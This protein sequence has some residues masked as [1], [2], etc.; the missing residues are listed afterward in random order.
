MVATTTKISISLPTETLRR[1]ERVLGRPHEGRSALLTRILTEAVDRALDE[2][3]AAG[4]RDQPVT[5]EEDAVLQ[6]AAR[7]GLA[8][9][10]SEE[11]HFAQR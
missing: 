10:T 9:A 11:Q 1:A 3:Y 2:Q 7:R 6:Q 8:D 5:P 4:Y